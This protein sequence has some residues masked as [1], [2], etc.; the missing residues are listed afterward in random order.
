MDFLLRLAMALVPCLSCGLPRTAPDTEAFPCPAC[1]WRIGEPIPAEEAEPA[2]AAESAPESALPVEPPSRMGI[3]IAAGL[4]AAALA[5]LIAIAARPDDRAPILVED[6][7]PRSNSDLTRLLFPPPLPHIAI[8][9]MPRPVVG[10]ETAPTVVLP[11]PVPVPEGP[12]II[13]V[14]SPASD[15]DLPRLALKN[16][17]KL[18][19]QARRL[20]VEG[21]DEGTVVDARELKLKAV[22]ITGPINRGSTLLVKSEGAQINIKGRID[23]GSRLVLDVPGGQVQFAGQ[24]KDASIG[25]GSR[26]TITARVVFLSGPVR[27][28]GTSVEITLTPTGRIEFVSLEDRARLHYRLD[29]RA[30]PL[31]RKKI[32]TVSG[33]AELIEEVQP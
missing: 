9:P 18:I 20:R 16:H 13:R 11:V 12:S 31:P 14:D 17:I 4:A 5:V 28:P 2:P 29:H 6:S 10:E 1:G 26:V 24:K 3:G 15:F 33:G 21:L 32:G 22:Y 23:G 27:G 7:R 8:A 25:G 30:D 19:G